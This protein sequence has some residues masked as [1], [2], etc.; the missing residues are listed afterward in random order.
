MNNWELCDP[1]LKDFE[2][3]V[4]EIFYLISRA[5]MEAYKKEGRP[6]PALMDRANMKRFLKLCHRGFARGQE[7]LVENLLTVRREHSN[8]ALKLKGARKEKRK[9]DV[10]RIINVMR[11]LEN[12]ERVLRS[13]A[14][15]LALEMLR[16]QKWVIHRFTHST[17]SPPFSENAIQAAHHFARMSNAAGFLKFSLVTDITSCI[18]AGDILQI[19]RNDIDPRISIIELKE[20]AVNKEIFQVLGDSFKPPDETLEAFK[21][22]HGESGIKQLTRI[23][24]QHERLS[25]A[26]S[27][28]ESDQGMDILTGTEIHLSKDIIFLENWFDLL[29]QI[30]M[31]VRKRGIAFREVEGVVQIVAHRHNFPGV[32]RRS[33]AHAIYHILDPDNPCLLKEDA[34]KE[35]SGM[36]DRL[37]PLMDL[38]DS[39]YYGDFLA[40]W[41]LPGADENTILDIL[42]GQTVV[43]MHLDPLGLIRLSEKMELPLRWATREEE[44]KSAQDRAVAQPMRFRHGILITAERGPKIVLGPGLFKRIWFDF[45][46]PSQLIRDTYKLVRKNGTV[47]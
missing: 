15:F 4:R 20:G 5:G 37:E 36:R 28:L 47:K 17:E 38:R 18:H 29:A 11:V 3:T 45:A 14:D 12:R 13:M 27:I 7:L 40:P 43:L 24:R 6:Q 10:S 26:I 39:I 30:L 19:D 25:A 1:L 41:V 44:A 9:E 22:R 46:L 31:D 34:Q 16:D 35:F 2:P 32:S 23:Q 21:A 42:F 8:Y 33:V